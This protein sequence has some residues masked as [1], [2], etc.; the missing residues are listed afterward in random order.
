MEGTVIFPVTGSPC[1]PLV[2]VLRFY[3]KTFIQDIDSLNSYYTL[4]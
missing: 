3:Q 2:T 4:V 1:L